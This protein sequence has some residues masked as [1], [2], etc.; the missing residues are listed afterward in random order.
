MLNLRI[1]HALW[2]LQLIISAMGDKGMFYIDLIQF[3]HLYSLFPGPNEMVCNSTVIARLP[4]SI[5]TT[6]NPAF[7][8]TPRGYFSGLYYSTYSSTLDNDGGI[9]NVQLTSVYNV[10]ADVTYDVTSYQFKSCPHIYTTYSTD[11][12]SARQDDNF[13]LHLPGT[14]ETFV[15]DILTY[16]RDTNCHEYFVGYSVYPAPGLTIN[17]QVESGPTTETLKEIKAALE[18]LGS[19]E[20]TGEVKK[21]GRVIQDG[22][23]TGLP[24]FVCSAACLTNRNNYDGTCSS[25]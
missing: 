3:V 4:P 11:Q 2:A 17:S 16:G 22:T 23:R 10:T 1:S 15:T 14:N 24:D 8:D 6:S 9:K 21:L 12:D 5:S 13:P 20:V 7:V 19:T 25:K 18:A